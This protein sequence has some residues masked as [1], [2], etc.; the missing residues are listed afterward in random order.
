ML[1]PKMIHTQELQNWDKNSR[2]LLESL[3]LTVDMYQV[4]VSNHK[5]GCR[6]TFQGQEKR[7]LENVRYDKN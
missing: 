3:L 4:P 7:V 1:I 2:Y 6:G 5:E